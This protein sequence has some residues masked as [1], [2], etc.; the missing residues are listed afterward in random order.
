MST[1][2]VVMMGPRGCGKS[3]I[4][5]VMLHD[6]Q[7]FI[8]NTMK[9]NPIFRDQAIAPTIKQVELL[10]NADLSDGMRILKN[11]C[12]RAR[13]TSDPFVPRVDPEDENKD[14][15]INP[16]QRPVSYS[17]D[18]GMGNYHVLLNFKD[19]PGGFYS[20]S[21]LEANANSGYTVWSP[22]EIQEW[23]SDIREADVIIVAVDATTQLGDKP[24][25]NDK[26]YYDR[27]ASL[28]RDSVKHSITTVIF[29]PVKCE[30][31]VLNV[32]WNQAVEQCKYNFSTSAC[33]DLRNEVDGLF[34]GLIDYFQKEDVYKNVDAYFAPMITIGGIRF[35]GMKFNAETGRAANSFVSA[36]P[37]NYDET[38]F[39]PLNC[40][41]VFALCLMRTYPLL[42]KGWKKEMG[43]IDKLKSWF[44]DKTP[45]E[46]FFASFAESINFNKMRFTYFM[47]HPEVLT[48]AGRDVAMSFVKQIAE[49]GRY[50]GCEAL[51]WTYGATEVY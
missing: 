37:E 36:I 31:R 10:A 18:F 9:N 50:D 14:E 43:P 2:N 6:I 46:E 23:E 21:K 11:L 13:V 12:N 51:N 7:Q 44:S 33:D 8:E 25:L 20:G 30:H 34:P 45:F 26:S 40:D 24:T 15:V 48:G 39:L 41:K 28:L 19:F 27:I 16:T 49:S 38:P 17:I 22:E 35:A 29:V 4:L 3:S 42:V 1:I 5:S 32:E 47:K